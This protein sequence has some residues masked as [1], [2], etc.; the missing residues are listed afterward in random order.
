VPGLPPFQATLGYDHDVRLNGDAT[1]SLSGELRYRSSYDASRYTVE[2]A[3]AGAAPF[4]RNGGQFIGNLSATL[5]FPKTG[6]SVTGYVRNVADT[7]YKSFLIPNTLEDPFGN[8]IGHN[9]NTTLS[10]PRT[11]GIVAS[12]KF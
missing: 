8:V 6:L 3:N 4:I 5:A 11:Y 10:D 1:L 9:Y 7:R 2:Q 12:V